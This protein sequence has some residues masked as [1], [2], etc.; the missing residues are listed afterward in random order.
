MA[1]RHALGRAGIGA[2]MLAAPGLVARSWVGEAGGSPGARV[3]TTALGGR[4]VA[5][6]LGLAR[7][8][9]SGDRAAPWLLAGVFA[10]AVDL[11][12][13]VRWRRSLPP[14][15]VVGIGALAAGSVVFGLYAER[16]LAHSSP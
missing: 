7:A 11:A 3:L 8:V 12:A 15:A 2:A 14:A 9:R 4:D 5:I 13:T 10:D 16:A 6:G 1:T